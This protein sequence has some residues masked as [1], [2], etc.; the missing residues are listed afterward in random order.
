MLGHRGEGDITIETDMIGCVQVLGSSL[1]GGGFR[2]LV[3]AFSGGV[4]FLKCHE[5]FLEELRGVFEGIGGRFR[6][7]GGC[8]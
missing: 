8:F 5:A 6:M 7:T 1:L 4:R 3:S 2:V